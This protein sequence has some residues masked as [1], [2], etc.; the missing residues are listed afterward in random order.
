[1]NLSWKL[2][3]AA[4]IVAIVFIS[5]I[6]VDY[7]PEVPEEDQALIGM[8]TKVVDG[9]TLDVEGVG[10][11]RLAD[12]DCPELGGDAGKR[13]AEYAKNQLDGREVEVVIT[14]DK[15]KYGRTVAHLYLLN[16]LGGREAH[17]NKMLVVSGHAVIKDY[18]DAYTPQEWCPQLLHK[19]AIVPY[20]SGERMYELPEGYGA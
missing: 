11:V 3:L 17:F 8:V 13:A 4:S 18:P 20:V 14:Q 7:L 9:D 15:D 1:M 10:R 16:P 2:I 6:F 12:V 19:Y 5:L